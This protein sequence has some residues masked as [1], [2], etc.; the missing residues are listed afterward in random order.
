[1]KRSAFW[2]LLL[3]VVGFTGPLLFAQ[4][5]QVVTAGPPTGTTQTSEWGSSVVWAF[6]SSS[7]MEWVK[8]N[9]RIA[10]LSER[11]AWGVQRGIGILLAIATAAGI[12]A[13]FDS[14]AGVLIIDGLLWSSIWEASGESIRQWVM[15]EVTYRVAVKNYGKGDA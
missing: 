5:Q 2:V 15:T 12:H 1:M 6:L 7:L 8:R 13:S 4:A 11:T 14:T 3:L 10:V 9:Q